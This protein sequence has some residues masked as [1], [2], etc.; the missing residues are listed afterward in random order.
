MIRHLEVPSALAIL[1]LIWF[2][3]SAN[4]PLLE[5]TPAS[6]PGVQAQIG[7]GQA[8]ISNR[9]LSLEFSLAQGRAR[10]ARIKN[11]RT[12]KSI[13]VD[14]ED[15]TMRFADG[16]TVKSTEFQL[17][18]PSE[19]TIEPDA[20]QL[21]L[22]L[23]REAL[24]VRMVTEMRA[25]EWWATRWLEITGSRHQL[26]N[27]G[28]ARW[29]AAGASGP[30]GPGKPVGSLGYPSGCGQIVY[31]NDLFLGI[32]HPGA[33]NFAGGGYISCDLPASDQIGEGIVVRTR[34]MVVG[35][36]DAGAA[37]R[38]FLGYIDA[39]R[40]VP[41]RM[42]FLVNDWYW[43]NKDKPVEALEALAEMKKATR[44]PID[45]FTLDDGWDFDWD[46]ATGIWGRLNRTRFPGGWESLR[47]A[48]RA[49]DIGVSLWFGP[50]GGYRDRPKRI[51]FARKMGFELNGDRLCL[52]GTHYRAHVIDSFSGWAAQ[53]MDYIKVDGFWPDCQI[54]GHGHPVGQGGAIAQMDSLMEVFAAWRRVR[55]NLVVGYTSGSN[56]S[57]FWL[58]HADFVWR[59]GS[60]DSHAGAGEPFDR[61]NTFLDICLQAH[62]S[63]EMPVSAF[64]T[65]DIV[66]GRIAGNRD[67]VFER[68]V[69]WLAARTSLHHDWYIQASD[70]T[71][72]RWKVLARAA[73]WAKS[74]EKLFRWSRMI[75]G[76]PAQGEVYGY[77]A[78]DDGRGVLAL[79]NPSSE[80]RT[81]QGSL[82]S[83]LDLP[84]ATRSRSFNLHGIFGKTRAVEGDRRTDAAVSFQLP[85][86][87]IAVFEVAPEKIGR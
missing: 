14:G 51:E 73:A 67:D 20:K 60:D 32:A 63:T 24:R 87:S 42:I 10:I 79:R 86:L 25:S 13:N 76:D 45:S 66:Q 12:G 40:A 47:T 11:L 77:A 28:L 31:F 70:L 62:R 3:H 72:E 82:A 38:A 7:R 33:E 44:V 64:V 17:T 75:G 34:K 50:I 85:P 30:S 2:P 53:G 59:G 58:Q 26:A 6:Q 16:H 78:F 52:A 35:S 54:P 1:T 49:A 46:D 27:V 83:L 5:R 23:S 68:G 8:I 18:K 37:R 61:H 65:F 22:E 81:F 48:G 41:A 36:G 43:N 21:V 57:P 80:P 39:T 69:W 4:T 19:V 9:Y 29:R 84:P 74:H 71:Q 56:P 55:P 15:F